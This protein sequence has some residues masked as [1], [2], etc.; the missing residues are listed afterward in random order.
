VL[1]VVSIDGISDLATTTI[2][3]RELVAPTAAFNAD[4]I[5]GTAPLTVFFTDTSENAVAWYWDFGEPDTSATTTDQHPSHTYITPGTYIA[6]LTVFSPDGLTDTAAATITVGE[7]PV[8]IPPDARFTFA[9]DP[10]K[11]GLKVRFTDQSVDMDG[12]VREWLWHFGDGTISTLQNPKHIYQSPGTF[13]V[14][15][16]VMDND[17]NSGE[18]SA[19]ITVREQN[20]GKGTGNENGRGNA[21]SY[22][23]IS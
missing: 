14:T 20:P 5:T 21:K 18:E 7:P 3:A 4:P 23:K 10:P 9:P 22:I 15:L 1:K 13:W 16:L 2:N 11:V 8:P 12:S 6:I 19:A 17:G